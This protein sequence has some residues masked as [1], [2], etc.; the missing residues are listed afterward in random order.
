MVRGVAYIQQG[1]PNVAGPESFP[2]NDARS[3]MAAMKFAGWHE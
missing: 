1:V 2:M 3:L